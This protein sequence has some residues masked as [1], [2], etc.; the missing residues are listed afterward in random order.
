VV[1]R[2]LDPTIGWNPP[3]DAAPE[4]ITMEIGGTTPS[5]I[6]G[7]DRVPKAVWTSCQDD[8]SLISMTPSD[9]YYNERVE[10]FW[11]IPQRVS[12]PDDPLAT[13]SICP[14]IAYANG[15]YCACL[16]AAWE[17]WYPDG[18]MGVVMVA[19]RSGTTAQWEAHTVVSLPTPHIR[20]FP[21]LTYKN[22]T[23]FSKGFDLVWTDPTDDF[24]HVV[25]FSG[26]SRVNPVA[27]EV[28]VSGLPSDLCHIAA[29]P[30][31]FRDRIM[32]SRA[33]SGRSMIQIFDLSGRRV[34]ELHATDAI[35]GQWIWDG[36]NS[37]GHRLAQGIYLVRIPESRIR[38]TRIILIR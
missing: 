10:A 23:D 11:Q 27:M 6:A 34:R 2:Y 20:R 38:P 12:L 8:P 7:P 15:P 29:W 13:A 5:I 24:S 30:N 4:D 36:R 28:A 26:T 14:T 3:L 21:S 22:G 25:R 37:A 35:N 19:M 32:L 1:Y 9:V 17:E 33:A 31:P 18:A 16:H